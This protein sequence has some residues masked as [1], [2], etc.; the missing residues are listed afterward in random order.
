MGTPHVNNI[1]TSV[2]GKNEI[3]FMFSRLERATAT[4]NNGAQYF[5]LVKCKIK[6]NPQKAKPAKL[7]AFANRRG[8]MFIRLCALGELKLAKQ[9]SW[10]LDSPHVRT[11]VVV[12]WSNRSWAVKDVLGSPEISVCVFVRDRKPNPTWTSLI[13]FGCCFLP[14]QFESDTL[15]ECL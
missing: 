14:L 12:R 13:S 9:R 4:L 6:N 5:L 3:V 2:N 11:K 1:L 10:P 8:R 7:P 15:P